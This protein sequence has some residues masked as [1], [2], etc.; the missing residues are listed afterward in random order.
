MIDLL[1]DTTTLPALRHLIVRGDS[2]DE[3]ASRLARSAWWHQLDRLTI[4]DPRAMTLSGFGR[5]AE[6][7][8]PWL[9]VRWPANDPVRTDGWEFAF[10]P[11]EAC[12][13]TLRGFTPEA[14][15]EALKI[16]LSAIPVRTVK[17]VASRY[18][19][20]T[21]ADAAFLSRDGLVV[22]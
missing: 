20:P 16:H 12:E 14:R 19:T 22:T 6:L 11:A 9:A 5:R 10:G 7:H 4:V 18:Y 13:A 17:L 2:A 8:V 15:R 3:A 21:A 1:R